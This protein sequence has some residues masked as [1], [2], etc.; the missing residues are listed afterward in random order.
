M[1]SAAFARQRRRRRGLSLIEVLVASLIIFFIFLSIVPLFARA[2]ASN[3]RGFETSRMTSFVASDL[4]VNNQRVLSHSS[5]NSTL[6]SQEELEQMAED[7]NDENGVDELE[8]KALELDP[9]LHLSGSTNYTGLPTRYFGTGSRDTLTEADELIGDEQW[10]NRADAEIHAGNILWLKNTA[11]FEYGMSDVQQGTASVGSSGVTLVG[12]SRLFD[13]PLAPT[14]GSPPDIR[15]IRV[16]LRSSVS[17]SPLN[18][19]SALGSGLYRS[20]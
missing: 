1:K 11:F 7:Q 3:A 10:L 8:E 12:S 4:E 18:T 15:E 2:K 9:V 20:F 14:P 5:F 16:F 6:N 19:G 13:N 17:A